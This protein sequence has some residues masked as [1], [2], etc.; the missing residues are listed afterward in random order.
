[1][2]SV[3]IDGLEIA[4]WEW[5]GEDPALV[6]AHATGFHA[7][8]WDRII[9]M[10]PG[11]H[12]VA[13]DFRGHGRSSKPQ[14]PYHWSGFVRDM[15]AVVEQLELRDAIGIGHSMG[16]HTVV[17][18]RCFTALVLID[19]TIFPVHMYDANARYDASFIRKRRNRWKSSDEMFERFR[20]RAPFDSWRPEILRDYCEYGLLPD[21]NEFVLACPPDI[22]ASIYEHSREPA[23]NLHPM[24]PSIT[25]P[26]SVVR[27][28]VA[29]TPDA[30][31]LAASPTAPDLAS[32][33]P[34]GRDV[35]LEGRNHFIP[36]AAPEL[37]AE[38]ICHVTSD[39]KAQSGGCAL[40]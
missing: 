11:Q 1:M 17:A 12:C 34:R 22:E 23:S 27:A 9:Q 15:Q 10:F 25:V 6:F 38:E 28:G 29:M 37:V 33:F 5:P 40:P 30:F 39:R 2:R 20:G 18:A 19:P 8:C 24:I 4:V 32:E 16:G 13:L 7:R 21:G 36:M 31:N 35:L 14:P 26:V 3:A